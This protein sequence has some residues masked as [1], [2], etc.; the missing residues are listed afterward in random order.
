MAT[1]FAVGLISKSQGEKF[2][3]FK[4]PDLL[5]FWTPFLLV[6]LGGPDTIT[7]FALE[8][9]E[10]WK[11]HAFGLVFQFRAVIYAFFQSYPYKKLWPPTVLMFIAGLIKYSDRTRAIYLA[12][13]S[14]FKESFLTEPDPGPNYVEL[15]DEYTSKIEA[16]LPTKIQMI[17][18]TMRVNR[19][20][21]PKERKKLTDLEV[22]QQAFKFFETLKGL[23]ADLIFSFRERNQSGDYFLKR[24]A[25][26]AFKI[27]EVE[28]NFFFEILY[29]KATVVHDNFGYL[30]RFLSFSLN[31]AALVV[32]HTIKKKEFKKFDIG[33]SYT[34][35]GGTIFLDVIAF[36]MVLRSDWTA[37]TLTKLDHPNW[38]IRFLKEMLR[39]DRK[40]W[41]DD[42][43]KKLKWYS[44]CKIQQVVW[45]RWS[46]SLSQ[47]N[48]IDYCLDPRV[49]W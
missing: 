41:P 24:T 18:E 45:R 23:I 6:H 1:T 17:P 39:V 46:E 37:V 42:P 44:L 2:G 5:A 30:L 16:R 9:N 8:D 20:E 13:S 26:A 19:I 31:V 11:R 14:R 28:L 48:L 33:I 25:R 15:M 40:R 34:L 22:L 29:T 36:L 47:Y 27:V 10:L 12:S 32:F 38:V 49:E 43:R 21:N 4:N 7:A 3:P 35:L